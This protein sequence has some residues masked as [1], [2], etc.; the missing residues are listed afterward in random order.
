[1]RPR[2]DPASRSGTATAGR[3]WSPNSS[4]AASESSTRSLPRVRVDQGYISD[5]QIREWQGDYGGIDFGLSEM[6]RRPTLAGGS[7]ERLV[8]M[9]NTT[10]TTADGPSSSAADGLAARAETINKVYGSGDAQGI[11]LND[12]AIGIPRGRFA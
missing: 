9:T 7:A 4:R 6:A 5:V 3:N 8:I 10:P 12:V 2:P 1:M 11:A